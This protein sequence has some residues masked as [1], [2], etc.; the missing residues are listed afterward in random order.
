M[1]NENKQDMNPVS[2]PQYVYPP[3]AYPQGDEINLLDIWRIL[4]KRKKM[5]IVISLLITLAGS[6]YAILKPE[7]YAYTTAI[8]IGSV[9]ANGKE[10]PVDEV[11]NA[12]SKIKEVYIASVLSD[13]Y[14]ENPGQAKNIKINASV[15]KDS[16]IL[17]IS[18]KC[19]EI[20]API[21][22]ELINKVSAK[23][24]KNHNEKIKESRSQLSEQIANAKKRLEL[25]ENNEKELNK[26][27]ESFDKTFKAAPIDNSSVT[28]LVIT[29]L[30]NQKRQISIDKL[31][32]QSEIT[33]KESELSLIQDS[34][35]LYPVTK[36][37]EPVS[38]DKKIMVIAFALAG[39]I[40]GVFV[41]L[42]WDF[43]EKVKGQLTA[44]D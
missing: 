26:R 7:I 14:R 9:F 11:K 20:Q 37:I 3:M 19:S 12:E 42:A 33:E 4:A 22:Q 30:S 34:K 43:F 2:A 15:P 13:F 39:F 17:I 21:Y 41:A 1:N 44:A 36:S 38:F 40:L 27:I 25:L 8:Q 29:T 6:A 23:L 28:V 24:V 18:G 35:L 16:E 31:S 10:E 32:L 5:V